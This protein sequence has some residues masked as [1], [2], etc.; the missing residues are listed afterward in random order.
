[1]KRIIFVFALFILSSSAFAG[2]GYNPR[3]TNS[4]IAVPIKLDNNEIYN[5]VVNVKFLKEPYDSR[6]YDADEYR[7]LIERL[8]VEWSS[9]A[10][11]VVLES[12]SIKMAE[13]ERTKKTIESKISQLIV[14]TKRKYEIGENIEVVYSI[15]S[16]YLVK[17]E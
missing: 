3:S 10:I 15:Y 9:I 1:M 11:Q 13:L 4:G 5:L 16:F 17:P 12:P 8:Q 6:P 7:K 2:L 14:T